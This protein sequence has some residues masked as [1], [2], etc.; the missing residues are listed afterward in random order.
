MWHSNMEGCAEVK[1]ENKIL[2]VFLL[3]V[4]G[5]LNVTSY[6]VRFHHFH[7]GFAFLVTAVV[8]YA[9]FCRK[10]EDDAPRL[11]FYLLLVMGVMAVAADMKDLI[12]LLGT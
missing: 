9:F 4:G 1:Y 8:V 3:A 5:V 12:A 10:Y 6:F 7:F 2:F 11:I